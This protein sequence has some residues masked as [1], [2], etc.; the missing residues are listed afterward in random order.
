[1]KNQI[2]HPN[3]TAILLAGGSGKRMGSATKKQ[4]MEIRGKKVIDYTLEILSPLV[5][6]VIVIVPDIDEI[7]SLKDYPNTRFVNSK[8]TRIQSIMDCI[9]EVST[10]YVLIHDASR[11]FLDEQIIENVISALTDYACAYP[12]IPLTSSIAIDADGFMDETPDRSKFREVQTPQ[13]FQTESLKQALLLKGEDHIHIPELVRS[14]GQKVKH[15]DGSPWLFKITYKP[16]IYA[17]EGYLQEHAQKQALIVGELPIF[18]KNI[19]DRLLDSGVQIT[20]L[21]LKEAFNVIKN[22][23]QIYEVIINYWNTDDLGVASDNSDSFNE[24]L[25]NELLN[26][27]VAIVE[28]NG[29]LINVLYPG[30]NSDD[31]GFKA[32]K[33]IFEDFAQKRS[34]EISIFTVC[35]PKLSEQ[36]RRS[37]PSKII[38]L[39]ALHNLSEISSQTFWIN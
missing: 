16:S 4:Y 11:P 23:D 32:R 1:M 36:S 6:E 7:T 15:I 10:E 28:N 31:N 14:L 9:D 24:N 20:N 30:S 2:K 19:N 35:I 33:T 17:A 18:N 39:C 13:G 38:A 5:K 26:K 3:T 25:I 29:V 34:G 21:E 27:E 12:V 22:L 8:E 37:D